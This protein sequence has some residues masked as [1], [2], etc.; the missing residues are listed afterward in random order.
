MNP[1]IAAI[2]ATIR[3]LESELEMEIARRRHEFAYTAHDRKV[4]FEEHVLQD[5]D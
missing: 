4:R 1:G 3:R 2:T 5:S